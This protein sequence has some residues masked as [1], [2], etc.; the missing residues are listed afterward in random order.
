M[1]AL[2]FP[3]SPTLNQL[4]TANGNTWQ[5]NGESWVSYTPSGILPVVNGG[6]GADTPSGAR[7][8]LSAQETLV[9]GTNIKTINS[10]SLL[11][12]GNIVIS[13]DIVYQ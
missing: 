1:A 11:G 4:Y 12:S 5:W 9:S 10:T 7:T 8:N 6:T 13:A 2:D 3:A